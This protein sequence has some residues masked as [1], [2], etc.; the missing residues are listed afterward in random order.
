MPRNRKLFIHNTVVLLTARTEEGLPFWP[1]LYMNF[2]LWGIL[3]RARNLYQVRVC[4]FIFMANHLHLL[5]VVDD[6]AQLDDFM[7]YIK[8]E[9]AHAVN[10]LWGR[11]KHTVWCDGYDSPTILTPADVIRYIVYIYTNPLH[12]RDH[13]PIAQYKGI[14]SWKLFQS[15]TSS[16]ACPWII[17][18]NIPKLANVILSEGKQKRILAI[19]KAKRAGT[20]TFF[21]EPNAWMEC[22]SELRADSVDRINAD[23]RQRIRDEEK[24]IAKSHPSPTCDQPDASRIKNYQ[25][26]KFSPRMICLCSDVPLRSHFLNWYRFLCEAAKAAFTRLTG[27]ARPQYPAG[28]FA[29]GGCLHANLLPNAILH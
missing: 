11:R 12:S 1:S 14:S 28:F 26:K 16:R 6:P 29:P 23:I 17:R 9:S 21:L 7:R 2:I 15:G 25:P 18:R 27:G 24:Q 4:H 20:K 5:G 3:A 8:T 22:F 19:L 10:R 13:T